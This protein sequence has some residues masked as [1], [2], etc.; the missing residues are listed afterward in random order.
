MILNP[1]QEKTLFLWMSHLRGLYNLALEQRIMNYKQFR[2][3]HSWQDQ[4]NE[5]PELKEYAT[6]LKDVPSQCLQQKLQDLHK[7][8]DKFFSGGG[9]P[10]FKKRGE[11][12]SMRFPDPKQFQVSVIKGKRKGFLKLPKIGLVKFANSQ[13]IFGKIKNCTIS[14]NSS[15]EFFVSIQSEYEQEIATHTG[16]IVGIDRGVQNFGMTSEAQVLEL[17]I[18]RIKTLEVKLAKEQKKLSRKSK[19][20]KNFIKQKLRVA[21][22]HQKIVNIRT[23]QIHQLSNE[24]VNNHGVIVLED[25]KIKNMTKSSK[26]SIAEPGKKVAQKSGLNRAILRNGWGEFARQ[27]EYKSAWSG[28]CVLKVR[29]HFTSQTCP[30]CKHVHSK[31]RNKEVFRCM[32][33]G[34]ENHADIVG[35]MNILERGHR[36]LVCGEGADRAFGNAKG[37]RS[38]VKQKPKAA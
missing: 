7:A 13:N 31:N 3:S 21:R 12:M 2:K 4:A 9:F 14:R 32:E 18:A 24:I 23:N 10:R 38:S 27:L 20:S 28:G 8:Y 37:R 25:L 15:G 35:A 26:G 36:L 30:K 5:L 19:G 22:V 34:F 29:P 6:W 11:G 33:C 17:P 1:E 16:P